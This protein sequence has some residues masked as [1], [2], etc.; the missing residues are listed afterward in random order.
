M[1]IECRDCGEQQSVPVRGRSTRVTC[2]GCGESGVVSVGSK[3]K[4]VAREQ[5]RPSDESDE[6][7]QR[8]GPPAWVVAAAVG[9]VALLMIALMPLF[10]LADKVDRVPKSEPDPVVD[11]LTETLGGFRDLLAT[12]QDVDS[13]RSAI[14]QLNQSIAKCKAAG[15]AYRKQHQGLRDMTLE[16]RREYFVGHAKSHEKL[17]IM[18]SSAQREW[19]RCAEDYPICEALLGSDPKLH[20][21]DLNGAIIVHVDIGFLRRMGVDPRTHGH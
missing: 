20:L 1:K 8:S 9:G 12:V 2:R 13:A 19:S 17:S 10:R 15:E 7:E 16:E 11:T 18:K 6:S 21:Q 4:R 3:R 5:T 14:A